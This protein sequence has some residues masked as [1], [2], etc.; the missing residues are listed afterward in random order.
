MPKPNE[1]SRRVYST[2]GGRTCPECGLPL[3][4]CPGHPKSS[5]PAGDGVVRLRREV[6]GR[7]G[8]TVT[9]ISGVKLNATDLTALAT[10]LKR[11]CGTGGSAKDGVIIIQGD[12]REKL[13]ALLRQK[14]FQVKLAGG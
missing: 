1:N 13:L 10:E 11:Q 7:G 14:G 12:H 6:K 4:T 5:Q 8:K 2:A 9:A 3:D